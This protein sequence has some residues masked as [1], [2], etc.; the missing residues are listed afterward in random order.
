MSTRRLIVGAFRRA[1]ASKRF[2]I[3][4][5]YHIPLSSVLSFGFVVRS[6]CNVQEQVA[7]T[8]VVLV[9]IL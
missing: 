4:F 8:E 9:S 1:S 5:G 2:N 3:S 6:D 7:P